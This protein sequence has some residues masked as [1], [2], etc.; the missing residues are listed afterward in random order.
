MISPN[1]HPPVTRPAQHAIAMHV[2]IVARD[3]GGKDWIVVKGSHP[4]PDEP[5]HWRMR[6]TS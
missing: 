1:Q 6:Q 4:N 3:T 5:Q 2:A